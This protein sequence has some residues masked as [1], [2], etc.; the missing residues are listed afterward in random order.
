[1]CATWNKEYDPDLIAK[2][3]EA[4]RVYDDQGNHRGFQGPY[5]DCVSVLHSSVVFSDGIPPTERRRII[6][7]SIRDAAVAGVIAP[8]ALLREICK[9]ENGY[10]R[11]PLKKLV[12]VTSLS[13]RHDSTFNN[14][15]VND[16]A[17]RFTP[18]LP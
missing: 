8:K 4:I 14:V 13:L 5:E 7:L 17:I 15:L 2:K 6:E 3:L 1:M 18:Q 12:L 10:V 16:A 11:L 9:Q